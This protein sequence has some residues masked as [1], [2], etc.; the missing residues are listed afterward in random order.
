MPFN[1][2]PIV[3]AFVAVAVTVTEPPKLTELPFK[4]IAL[5]VKLLLPMLLNVF[6]D[7]SIV[8]P[9]NVLSVPPNDSELEPMV[10]ELLVNPLLGIVVLI[11]LAGMLIVVL[12]AAVN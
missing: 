4:V 1:P 7:P 2:V 12:L 11:A 6:V 9:A 8:T 10:T 5:L 3:S